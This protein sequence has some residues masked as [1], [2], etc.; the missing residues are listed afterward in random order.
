MN[1][2]RIN[3]VFHEIAEEVPNI[4]IIGIVT[5]TNRF[6]S[7]REIHED[8]FVRE[9]AEKPL[10]EAIEKRYNCKFIKNTVTLY[11]KKFRNKD[12]IIKIDD[13]IFLLRV[14][15]DGYFELHRER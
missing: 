4:H 8:S 2:E 9:E 1:T 12:A 3:K 15:D 5:M 11:G 7:E 13:D 6:I 14:T 10:L